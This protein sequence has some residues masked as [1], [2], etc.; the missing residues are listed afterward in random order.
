MELI[1]RMHRQPLRRTAGRRAFT[2]FEITVVVLIIGIAAASILIAVGG[3]I[4][5]SKLANAANVLAADIEFC[6]GECINHPDA[7]RQMNF[8]LTNNKYS[9]QIGSTVV[10]HPADSLPFINDFATG[11]N[12]QLSGVTLSGLAMG[13]GSLNVLTFD[14]YGRPAITADF[15]ITLTYRGRTMRV[16]VKQTTGDVTIQ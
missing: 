1:K 6:Q 5:S 3:D 4:R 16:T 2:L 12:A 9:V 10:S 11:R 15:V 14:A 8:D 7:L 13:S